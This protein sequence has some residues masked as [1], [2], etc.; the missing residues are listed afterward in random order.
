MR[1]GNIIVTSIIFGMFFL[2][3][4]LSHAQ[5]QDTDITLSVSPQFPSPGDKVVATLTSFVVDLNKANMTWS[6]DGETTSSG[7]GKKTFSFTL[8]ALG[9][10][11]ELVV[12]IQTINRQVFTKRITL[13]G[14]QVD[15]LWEAT[16]S[17]TPP[18]YRGK[19]LV[20]REGTYKVVALP[21]IIS[22]NGLLNPNTLSY[23]WEKDDKGQPE[24]SGWGKTSFVFK[25]SYIDKT[26]Q[27]LVKISDAFGNV[28]ASKSI[29]LEP[30]TPKILFYKKNSLLGPDL[31]H[32]LTDGHVVS[33]NGET[34]VAVP[35]FF[36]PKNLFSNDLLVDW[37]INDNV[38]QAAGAKNEINIKG[39]EGKS[40]QARIKTT[41]TNPSTLFLNLSKELNVTF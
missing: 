23:T 24:A 28:T 16:N 36:S 35:Y 37:K 5:V 6:L 29:T 8:G 20:S 18:F 17:Y 26:N 4:F 15:M 11:N 12:D 22:Q 31:A 9:T 21:S 2:A 39:E 1:K 40:G 14:T 27:V 10:T 38:A 41:I 32:S 7:V 19:A 33:K 30:T 25:N 34:V 3:P 13:G